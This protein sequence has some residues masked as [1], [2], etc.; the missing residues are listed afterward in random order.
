MKVKSLKVNKYQSPKKVY[1]L[2][3]PKDNEFVVRVGKTYFLSK[4]SINFLFLYNG[5]S[6]LL[7]PTIE[8]NWTEKQ[9]DEYIEKNNC[10]IEYDRNENKDLAYTIAKDIHSK[11]M[12]TYKNIPIYAQRQI[13]KGGEQGYIDSEFGSRR[14]LPELLYKQ[15]KGT[16]EYFKLL[17]HNQNICTNTEILSMEALMMHKAM[18]GVHKELKEREMKSK[19]IIMVHDSVVLKIY[20]SELE[21]VKKLCLFHLQ[22]FQLGDVPIVA[23]DIISDVWGFK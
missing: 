1:C 13:K 5:S 2:S 11:F 17:N 21:E 18:T 4:N 9:I 10:K 15:R 14:H 3:I 16:K 6:Y 22:N 19:L 23:E 7:K 8:M 12:S 20:K